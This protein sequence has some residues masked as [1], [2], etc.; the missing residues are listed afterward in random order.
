MFEAEIRKEQE[1]IERSKKDP[2]Q[3]SM[4]SMSIILTDFQLHL[5]TNG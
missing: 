1:V 2:Q 3:V 5:S 4:K